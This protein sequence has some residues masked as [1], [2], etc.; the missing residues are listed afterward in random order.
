METR[1]EIGEND[2]ELYWLRHIY[3]STPSIDETKTFI[4]L[5]RKPLMAADSTCR[6]AHN[7]SNPIKPLPYMMKG[8]EYVPCSFSEIDELHI[9]DSH[10]IFPQ[11]VWMK[12]LDTHMYLVGNSLLMRYMEEFPSKNFT[13]FEWGQYTL[14]VN[15]ILSSY[16]MFSISAEVSERTRKFSIAFLSR[17]AESVDEVMNKANDSMVLNVPRGIKDSASFDY[18]RAQVSGKIGIVSMRRVLDRTN[19]AVDDIVYKI[20]GDNTFSLITDRHL[21][22]FK[23]AFA[24]IFN[25]IGVR[26]SYSSSSSNLSPPDSKS[27][28]VVR[29][30][31]G[32]IALR[33][34]SIN[35][36]NLRT[37][38]IF[39]VVRSLGGGIVNP[40]RQAGS[41]VYN[42]ISRIGRG[43]SLVLMALATITLLAYKQQITYANIV[44]MIDKLKNIRNLR[45]VRWEDISAVL[46][47]IGSRF[48]DVLKGNWEASTGSIREY[49]NGTMD[50]IPNLSET[51]SNVSAYIRDNIRPLF[52]NGLL[53]TEADSTAHNAVRGYFNNQNMEI[54]YDQLKDTA[55][56]MS[57][58]AYYVTAAGGLVAATLATG[59]LFVD[60]GVIS[61]LARTITG[62]G[63]QPQTET[64]Y[65]YK[66]LESSI[67]G[68]KSLFTQGFNTARNWYGG[69]SESSAEDRRIDA[70][71]VGYALGAA[72]AGYAAYRTAKYFWGSKSVSAGDVEKIINESGTYGNPNKGRVDD[73][74]TKSDLLSA[75]GILGHPG[76]TSMNTIG[77]SKEGRIVNGGKAY[78]V[79]KGNTFLPVLIRSIHEGRVMSFNEKSLNG[80]E[81]KYTVVPLSS[82]VDGGITHNHILSVDKVKEVI[83]KNLRSGGGETVNTSMLTLARLLPYVHENLRAPGQI[84]N[85]D[86]LGSISFTELSF[87]N[88][89]PHEDHN[90]KTSMVIDYVNKM[91]GSSNRSQMTNLELDSVSMA[92]NTDTLTSS[93]PGRVISQQEKIVVVLSG[94]ES[95]AFSS[96]AQTSAA[97]TAKKLKGMNEDNRTSKMALSR[98]IKGKLGKPRAFTTAD[99]VAIL[100]SG[101]DMGSMSS[102]H[103]QTASSG[104]LNPESEELIS[105]TLNSLGVEFKHVTLSVPEIENVESLIH[106]MPSP[107]D[108]KE[109]SD[110][111]ATEKEKAMNEMAEKNAREVGADKTDKT[112]ES[113]K[114]KAK[115][116]KK[117][118][119]KDMPVPSTEVP[120]SG[121]VSVSIPIESDVPAPVSIPIESA[122]PVATN[123]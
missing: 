96:M 120:T 17:I 88:G 25:D 38:G 59:A 112:P 53:N 77:F 7:E 23:N 16:G 92:S 1:F 20:T 43:P 18:Y 87:M 15:S 63:A 45:S 11:I 62:A 85:I 46:S 44:L 60:T 116:A 29:L 57:S 107:H 26:L 118:K 81:A 36:P 111:E 70:S 123:A 83:L 72:A 39:S 51:M 48:N 21:I 82:A 102:T 68:G 32:L 41:S 119:D 97:I 3:N 19:K 95:S 30:P 13:D 106:S 5:E 47:D 113:T 121:S 94:I 61:G 24:N 115:N 108:K 56:K 91:K 93:I 58:G 6:F 27:S 86:G 33:S 105:D 84:I 37:G 22:G 65:G 55:S 28:D 69:R 2:R 67:K 80:M 14:I 104:L 101:T 31:Y 109:S 74:S 34:Y 73:E 89:N 64:G 71:T 9:Y 114:P 79:I 117:M 12:L 49:I 8:K 90:L 42:L 4:T 99:H 110:K 100:E 50:N 122:V 75:A 52:A 40:I 54:T 78:H 98:A 103:I 66:Y 76:N 10:D 35:D